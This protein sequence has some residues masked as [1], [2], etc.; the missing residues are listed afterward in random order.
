MIT[1][2]TMRVSE[3]K[4]ALA[5]GWYTNGVGKWQFNKHLQ[6]SACGRISLKKLQFFKELP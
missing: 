3:N 4:A 5:A 2:L 1:F 6:E